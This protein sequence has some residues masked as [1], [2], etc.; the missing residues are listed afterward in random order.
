MPIPSSF[1]RSRRLYAG[2]AAAL[3]LGGAAFWHWRAGAADTPRYLSAPVERGD[4]EQTVLASGTLE[5]VEQV[6]VGAQVSGQIKTLHVELGQ[7]VKQGQP[8]AEIDSLPQQ[9]ALRQAQASL[10]NVRAQKRAKQAALAQ[11]TLAFERQRQL[12]AADA[13]SRENFEA[14]QA[15]LETSRAEV[16]ALDAQIE[17]SSIA[18]DTARLNLGYTRIVAPIDGKVVAVLAREGQTVNAAQQAP[19]LIK[20]AKLETVTVKAEISEAD[21]TRV[22]PGQKLWFT[23]LGEPE[24]RYRATLRAIEPAPE[25]ISSDSGSGSSNSTSSSSTTS[26]VYYRGLFDV[27]NPDGKLRISMTAQVHIVLGEARG[28]LTV[29]SAALGPRGRDGRHEVRVL[30]A[31]GRAQPRPVRIGLNDNIRAV[32]LDGLREGERVVVGEAGAR[33]AADAGSRRPPRLRL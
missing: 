11:A 16:A 27:P 29:P 19:T 30:D 24:R 3:V 25:S 21:V 2:L 31:E 14:A 4:V 17:Q 33:P 10:N 8:I 15:Q 12:L 5:A 1:L 20:L 13:G 7:D 6:S 23:I 18:V 28:V 22:A 32:V 9:N 26:A